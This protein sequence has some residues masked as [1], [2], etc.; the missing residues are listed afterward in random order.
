MESLQEIVTAQQAARAPRDDPFAERVVAELLLL[1]EEICV[2]RDRL[3]SCA[4]LAAAG[5]PCSRAAIDAFEPDDSIIAERLAEH[6][7]FYEELFAQLD[8][9]A[10]T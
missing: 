9:A 8:D 6:R 10:S 1:A 3:D 7:A 4:R 5:K 2:L